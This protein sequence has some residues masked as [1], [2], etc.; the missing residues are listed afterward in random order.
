MCA[1]RLLA[2]G[3]DHRHRP[4]Q[5][6]SWLKQAR[7]S[8]EKLQATIETI[9]SNARLCKAAKWFGIC[10]AKSMELPI[11]FLRLS[12][13]APQK[14]CPRLAQEP[15]VWRWH[16]RVISLRQLNFYP[17]KEY[18]TDS[19]AEWSKALASGASPQGR[20]FEPHS[21]HLCILFPIWQSA[22]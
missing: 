6:H 11:R 10:M 14:T 12:R 22:E 13:H 17:R 20:G 18:T 9:A 5:V 2:R 19:L 15:W 21:C 1:N 16:V 8:E 3:Y 7:T 4:Q